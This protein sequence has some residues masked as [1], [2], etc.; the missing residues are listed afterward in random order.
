MRRS[1][2]GISMVAILALKL[3]AC[4]PRVPFPPQPATPNPAWR[5]EFG[6]TGGFAGVDLSISV[7]SEGALTAQDLRN[8]QR[9]TSR[10]SAGAIRELEELIEAAPPQSPGDKPSTCADCFRY[11]LEITIAGRVLRYTAD[12]TTVDESGLRPL[13]DYLMQLRDKTLRGDA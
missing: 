1:V 2:M 3:S 4:A 10:L 12:D 5:M 7:S 6:Q 9:V 11:E 8:G 13:I